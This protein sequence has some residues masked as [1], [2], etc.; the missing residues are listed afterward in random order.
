MQIQMEMRPEKNP[1]NE[2]LINTLIAYL[3]H[4]YNNNHFNEI[5]SFENLF[6]TAYIANMQNM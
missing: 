6:K 3:N 1:S 2:I 4:Q 5:I